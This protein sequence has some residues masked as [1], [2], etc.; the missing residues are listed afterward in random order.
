MDIAT[1]VV[2]FWIAGVL[3]GIA[4]MCSYIAGGE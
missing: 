1:F 3:F 2:L 4:G